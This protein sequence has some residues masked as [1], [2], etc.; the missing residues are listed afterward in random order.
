MKTVNHGIHGSL[1]SF[2][3]PTE[4]EEADL[5][6]DWFV[7]MMCDSTPMFGKEWF[8]QT[9]E[10]FNDSML[11]GFLDMLDPLLDY[12][13]ASGQDPDK[14]VCNKYWEDNRY[15]HTCLPG[16][17]GSKAASVPHKLHTMLH[18]LVP[19][20]VVLELGLSSFVLKLCI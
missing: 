9:A 3:A 18:S 13:Q 16:G 19:A 11:E 20:T 15:F 1:C 17:L 5:F 6:D 7:L 4:L 2:T 12:H 10:L 8:V 14:D